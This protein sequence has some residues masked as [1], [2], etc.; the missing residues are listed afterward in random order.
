MQQLQQ[1]MKRYG[2]KKVPVS[3]EEN[4]SD[5]L[6]KAFTSNSGPLNTSDFTNTQF[7]AE[8]LAHEVKQ[9]LLLYNAVLQEE[10]L[11][12][13]ITFSSRQTKSDM[14]TFDDSDGIVCD[15]CGCDIFQSFFECRRCRDGSDNCN[16]CS[17][18]YVEGRSCN[19]GVMIPMQCRDFGILIRS[20]T[21][22][23]K[24]LEDYEKSQGR[25]FQNRLN[26]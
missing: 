19:C 17:G 25:H 4:L 21:Q 18:C 5:T 20:R 9:L 24:V 16:I 8:S 2:K 13:G 22:V 23:V 11:P 6:N 14:T 3:F 7:D 15:F 26:L 12:I 1:C 10:S